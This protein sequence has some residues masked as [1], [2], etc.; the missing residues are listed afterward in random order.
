MR[1]INSARI[2]EQ[3]ETFQSKEVK[4]EK[5]REEM[6]NKKRLLCAWAKVVITSTWLIAI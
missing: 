4:I 3:R 5:K 2:P 1:P 6:N